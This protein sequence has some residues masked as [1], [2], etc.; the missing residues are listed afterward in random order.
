[1][2]GYF[3]G[4]DESI[5]RTALW[6]VIVTGVSCVVA[7]TIQVLVLKFNR[8]VTR[9]A[10]DNPESQGQKAR[11]R[12]MT[13]VRGDETRETLIR[14][15]KRWRLIRKLH[16]DCVAWD[17]ML[18][19]GGMA[20]FG[21]CTSCAPRISRLRT[22]AFPKATARRGTERVKADGRLVIVNIDS[23]VEK[24]SVAMV[25]ANPLPFPELKRDAITEPTPDAASPPSNK[26]PG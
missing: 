8:W 13:P 16:F 3:T 22:L 25:F 11:R 2:S 26:L 12:P 5:A 19:A 1:M 10:T 15:L 23:D 24:R 18:R 7:M 20:P 4:M 17:A 21:A 9:P 14:R 6:F